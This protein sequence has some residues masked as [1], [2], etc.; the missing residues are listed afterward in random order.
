MRCM[1]NSIIALTGFVLFCLQCVS[2]AE[3]EELAFVRVHNGHLYRGNK[4][5]RLW[6]MNIQ[7]PNAPGQSDYVRVDANVKRLKALGFNAVRL[8]GGNVFCEVKNGKRVYHRYAKGD[9]SPLDLMDYCIARLKENG[10]IIWLTWFDYASVTPGDAD[11]VKD[12][13]TRQEWMEAVKQLQKPEYGKGRGLIFYF[14]HRA[15]KAFKDHIS[16]VLNHFN[17]YTGLAV[18]DDPVFG[19]YELANELQFMDNMLGVKGKTGWGHSSVEEILPPFFVQELRQAWNEFLRQ[20]YGS[21]EALLKSWGKLDEGESLVRGAV[22]L[23]PTYETA[24]N[25]PEQRGR[26]IVDFYRHLFVETCGEFVKHIRKQ[27][28][29]VPL[30]PSSS[31]PLPAFTDCT[32][33]TATLLAMPLLTAT[34]G[35]SKLMRSD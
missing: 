11:L 4:C 16:K 19:I 24:R 8:W 2:F 12:P 35:H 22:K 27:G 34:I 32:S 3:Q 28:K 14:D 18:K 29:V 25:Y 26:D 33:L 6:G 23:Q 31:T 17:Q 1:K 30:C 10:F 5:L 15:K 21:D 9:G 20:R 7:G 13:N